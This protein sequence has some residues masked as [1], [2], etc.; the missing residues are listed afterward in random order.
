[1]KPKGPL[2]AEFTNL[3]NLITYVRVLLIPVVLFFV[4]NDSGAN[5]MWAA[6]VY[7]VAS[8]TDALDG[9]VARVTG[10]V[11]TLGKFLDPLADKLAVTA[12][13]ITLIPLGRV[14]AWIVVVVICREL[15]ITALRAVAAGEGLIIAAR[16]S[17]KTKTAF[18]LIAIVALLIHY[19][20]SIDL[21]FMRLDI[22]FHDVGI[23]ML[24]LS[25]FFSLYSAGAY[26][27]GF[28]QAL[29]ASALKA[30]A[31]KTEMA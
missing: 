8:I 3:P 25:V 4:V 27:R 26:F 7:S 5:A 21:L 15:A 28:V 16:D 10:Q 18:Q 30:R 14:P 20:Y 22:F 6:I 2:R 11:S 23:W 13:L 1:M 9:Y 29:A 31:D 17:A 19:R 24:Y 12:V